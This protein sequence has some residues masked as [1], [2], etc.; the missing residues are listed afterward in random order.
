MGLL[1][2]PLVR[3]GSEDPNI[4]GPGRPY[5]LDSLRTQQRHQHDKTHTL[6]HTATARNQSASTPHP[7]NHHILQQINNSSTGSQ[8][9]VKSKSLGMKHSS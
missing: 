8:F 3:G 7:R 2:L 6:Q 1:P 9:Q 4:T 5:P